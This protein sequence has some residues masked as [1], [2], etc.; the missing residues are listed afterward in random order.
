M[1]AKLSDLIPDDA[2]YS[3]QDD[4]AV[5]AVEVGGDWLHVTARLSVA[6]EDDDAA[7]AAEYVSHE[8]TG[9]GEVAQKWIDYALRVIETNDFGVQA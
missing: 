4:L 1:N 5:V 6:G 8:W 7:L 2:Q 9:E 3:T